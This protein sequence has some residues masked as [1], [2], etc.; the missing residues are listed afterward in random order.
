M[1]GSPGGLGALQRKQ[2]HTLVSVWHTKWVRVA[3]LGT[4]SSIGRS[5]TP[6]GKWRA[7]VATVW[8][9]SL[10]DPSAR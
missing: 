1:V 9:V 6:A 3:R 2:V 10:D 5:Q 8:P 7:T 4:P